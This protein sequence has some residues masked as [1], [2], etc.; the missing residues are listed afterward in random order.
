MLFFLDQA[1]NVAKHRLILVVDCH[2][3]L[4]SVSGLPSLSKYTSTA[5]AYRKIPAYATATSQVRSSSY[6]SL[7]GKP[8]QGFLAPVPDALASDRA[9]I[10]RAAALSNSPVCGPDGPPPAPC[11]CAGSA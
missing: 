8:S 3:S 2:A 11:S 7:L 5:G 6:I 9:P 10:R 4:L 1:V